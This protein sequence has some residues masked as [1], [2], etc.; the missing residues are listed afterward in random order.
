MHTACGTPFYVAPEVVAGDGYSGGLSDCWSAGVVLYIMLCGFPPFAEDDMALLFALIM[1][2]TY[3]FP[4][5]SWD[6]VSAGAKE[7]VRMLLTVDVSKRPSPHEFLS[8]CKWA[9]GAAPDV[10]LDVRS[11]LA[12]TQSLA[13]AGRKVVLLQRLLPKPR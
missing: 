11:E 2:G 10:C 5:P 7:A 9:S 1:T 3:N 12:K 6:S 13:R 8:R 4:S